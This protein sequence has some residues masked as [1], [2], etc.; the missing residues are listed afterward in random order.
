[1]RNLLTV[2]FSV[3]VAASL[4]AAAPPA[5]TPSPKP[6]AAP[7]AEADLTTV[8]YNV[9]EVLVRIPDRE[10]FAA[11]SKS[12]TLVRIVTLVVV[13]EGYNNPGVADWRDQLGRGSADVKVLGDAMVVRQTARGHVMVADLLARLRRVLAAPAAPLPAEPAETAAVRGRLGR[14]ITAKFD[15]VGL[16]DVLDF[17]GQAASGLKITCDPL[18]AE[19]GI[20]LK[21]R[22][23]TLTVKDA[24]A[25]TVLHFVLLPALT[26]RIQRD[27]IF[28][29]GCGSVGLA[30]EVYPVADIM[31]AAVR[32]YS[33]DTGAPNE[34]VAMSRANDAL[35][36]FLEL[37]RLSISTCADP[38]VSAWNEEGGPAVLVYLA[39]ALVVTQ[40]PRGQERVAAMLAQLRQ[41]F[42][43][44]AQGKGARPQVAGI[45]E[46]PTPEA[47]AV[48]HALDARV[49]VHFKDTPL[50]QAIDFLAELKPGLNVL[51]DRDAVGTAGI[52]LAERKVSL[53]ARRATRESVLS[54]ILGKDLGYRVEPGCILV[55]SRE[56]AMYPL[57][58][59]MYPVAD[60]RRGTDEQAWADEFADALKRAVNGK[61][62]A[63]Y[64]AW[65][66][67]GGPAV[68]ECFAGLLVVAQTRQGHQKVAQ[69]VADLR[70]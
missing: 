27:G 18:L 45:G 59:V 53:D 56:R 5:Q 19:Q 33:A 7:V 67:E 57:A 24:P 63:K 28:V 61:A 23:V 11:K 58:L 1:M 41:A 52:D 29:T 25:E 62:D 16:P 46:P 55:T 48:A 22:T 51:V 20:D 6:A 34:V 13:R 66:T 3:A 50:N 35:G 21:T 42:A 43:A 2:V 15:S 38:E 69:F 65:C 44:A 39:G 10:R 70:R 47:T 12:D 9:A 14:K 64:A 30:L 37:I 8:T 4:F 49:E 36:R 68:C 32:Y 26:Y 31:L 17:I 40:T 54:K 60:L